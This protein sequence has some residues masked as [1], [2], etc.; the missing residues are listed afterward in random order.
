MTRRPFL[1]HLTVYRRHAGS[2]AVQ[3]L[4]ILDQCECPIWVHGRLHGKFIRQSLETRSV[5]T[6]L[7]K[8]DGLI[9]A[10]PEP[11][12]AGADAEPVSLECAATKFLEAKSRRAKNTK[13]LYKRN[14]GNFRTFAE[15]QRVVMLRDVKPPLLADFLNE[16]GREWG[17]RTQIT[18]L[19]HLRAF[20]N[21]CVEME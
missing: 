7:S 16:H 11:P 21:W 5:H 12:E 9:A 13:T 20:F 19:K 14:V 15:G 2:C 6:A 3:H 10:N 4:R 18:A 8:R 1:N 17:T